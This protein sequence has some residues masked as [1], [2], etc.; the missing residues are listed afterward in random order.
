MYG[1]LWRRMLPEAVGCKVDPEII[2]APETLLEKMKAAKNV[3]FI[4]T[5]TFLRRFCAYADQYE[6]PRNCV[7]IITS[8]ALLDAK[9]SAAAKRVFGIAPQEIFGSTETG[10]VAW[11]RQGE[12]S[13]EYDWSVFSPVSVSLNAE[14]RLV[15]VRSPFSFRRGYVMGDGA[16]LSPDAR[17]FKLLGRKDRIVKIAEQRISLPD[18]EERIRTMDG[19]DDVA[20]VALERE[21]GLCLGA[22]I[23]TKNPSLKSHDPQSVFAMR[24]LLLPVFPRGSVPRRFRFVSELPCNPQGKVLVSEMK[25]LLESDDF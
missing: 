23:A 10:G 22:V 5:P 21:K 9:T 11:R 18:M 2:L 8:G 17:S 15:V 4:T 3:F 1:T 19:I 6:V 13:S 14:G 12:T 24:R 16:E 7:E 25:R 20:L